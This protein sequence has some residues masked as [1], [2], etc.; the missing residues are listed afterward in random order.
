[1]YNYSEWSGAVQSKFVHQ[2]DSASISVERISYFKHRIKYIR[3]WNNGWEKNRVCCSSSYDSFRYWIIRIPLSS[4]QPRIQP[5]P[6]PRPQRSNFDYNNYYTYSFKWYEKNVI[7][8]ELMNINVRFLFKFQQ[9]VNLV[10]IDPRTTDV[11]VKYMNGLAHRN[12]VAHTTNSLKYL[13]IQWIFNIIKILISFGW[14]LLN[15]S[16]FCLQKR[17]FDDIMMFN[18]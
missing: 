10:I 6:R 1:M 9:I 12:G 3:S 5:Q 4:L 13:Q 16:I 18:C 15:K 14:N 2:L 17:L 7:V 8:A 11:F